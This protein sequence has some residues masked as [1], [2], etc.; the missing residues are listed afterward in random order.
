MDKYNT[1]PHPIHEIRW[2]YPS[3]I[4]KIRIIALFW[5]SALLAMGQTLVP[6]GT[7][8]G[9]DFE[10]KV[11]HVPAIIEKRPR[12][13]HFLLPFCS[14]IFWFAHP[15]FLTSALDYLPPFPFPLHP[16][17]SPPDTLSPPRHQPIPHYL[18]PAFSS[19][20]KWRGLSQYSRYRKNR[21]YYFTDRL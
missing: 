21:V 15:I 5:H 4:V 9:V 11:G 8:I 2:N 14:S 20:G 12:I 13:Y 19:L 7:C 6:R 3:Y 10:G 18:P 17:L 1:I 16:P